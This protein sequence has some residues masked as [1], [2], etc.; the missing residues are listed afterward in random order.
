MTIVD[1]PVLTAV[2]GGVDTHV[3]FHVAAALDHIGGLL[4]VET[5]PVSEAGYRSLLD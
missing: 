4:G 1:S 3:D 2:T 5:F